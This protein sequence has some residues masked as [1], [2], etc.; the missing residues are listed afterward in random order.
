MLVLRKV[1]LALT[2][3][4]IC[5]FLVV[6][7]GGNLILVL[8]ESRARVLY[9]AYSQA[10]GSNPIIAVIAYVN[11]A[12][13]IFH[14]VYG[15]LITLRNRRTRPV[16]YDMNRY[17]DNSSWTSQNM[18]LLGSMLLAF[19]VLHLAN[20]W[21]KMKFTGQHLDLYQMV[22]DLFAQETYALIY[23][24]AMIPLGLHLAHGFSSAFKSL[25]LY[26]RKYLNWVAK[27][28]VTFAALAS[29]GFAVI[30]IV[31]YVRALP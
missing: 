5:L 20:F 27:L 7:L 15:L 30:P 10:I 1:I 4:F 14:I 23:I 29:F 19:T 24:L 8:P 17:R 12:C 25:G 26:H 9:N 11:Y 13:F 21:Y 31:V 22:V 18:G 6:H 2:G 16:G 3:L 28:G